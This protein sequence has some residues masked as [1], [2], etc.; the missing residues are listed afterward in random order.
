M[1]EQIVITML[2]MAVKYHQFFKFF[3]FEA[4]YLK[5]G[6]SCKKY[7]FAQHRLKVPKKC[8]GTEMITIPF[9][10]RH[11]SQNFALLQKIAVTQNFYPNF[12]IVFFFIV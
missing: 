9:T 7:V 1:H 3:H 11:P 2:F 10:T 8:F 6:R 5:N 4:R 12:F